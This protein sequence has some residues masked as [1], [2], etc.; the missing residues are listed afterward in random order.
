MY[1]STFKISFLV[2][3]IQ[4]DK[5]QAAKIVSHYCYF[6]ILS[7]DRSETSAFERRRKPHAELSQMVLRRAKRYWLAVERK[8]N[9]IQN[10][11]KLLLNDSPSTFQLTMSLR[12]V[13]M[14]SF[15]TRAYIY[16]CMFP[17][18]FSKSKWN[19]GH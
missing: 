8:E 18:L 14:L 3:R 2:E 16:I 10:I 6:Q 13:T 17:S 9:K 7:A 12:W 4:F 15:E 5:C 19:E 11:V 1:M